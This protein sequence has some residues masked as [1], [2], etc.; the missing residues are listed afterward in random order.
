[1]ETERR[2]A[3]LSKVVTNAVLLIVR[4]LAGKKDR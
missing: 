1:M 4:I 3:E 2:S